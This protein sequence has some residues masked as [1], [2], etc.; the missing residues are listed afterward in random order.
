MTLT[1]TDNEG[2]T[3]PLVSHEV[4]VT[5]PPASTVAFRGSA[6]ANT[7]ATSTAIP[8]PTGTQTGDALL[9]FVTSNTGAS[10]ATPAGWT[11]V[12]DRLSGT[13]LRTSLYRR[14]ATTGGLGTVTFPAI[15]K[16]N[17]TVLAYDGANPVPTAAR[18]AGQVG[19]VDEL[20]DPRSGGV[21]PRVVGGVLLGDEDLDG[22]RLDGAGWHRP[23]GSRAPAPGG[24]LVS[25]LAADAGPTSAAA[26]ALTAT[27]TV[28]SGKATGWT[29]VLQPE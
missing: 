29:V 8:T 1:V 26:P 16:T 9:L 25:G 15:T 24:G 19:G 12:S 28:S 7:N 22:S 4:T 11:F 3:S 20:P 21:D 5:D 10:P 23:E 27:S 18:V 6:V 13:D 2:Q 14:A 17:L